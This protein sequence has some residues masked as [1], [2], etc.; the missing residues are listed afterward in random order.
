VDSN[1]KG[2]TEAYRIADDD[3]RG[4]YWGQIWDVRRKEKIEFRRS[5]DLYISPNISLVV[6]CD[7]ERVT[8]MRDA[9]YIQAFG[10]E[11]RQMKRV[12]RPIRSLEDNI[13]MFLADISWEGTHCSNL[14][15]DKDTCRAAV[16]T[17]MN[18][19]VP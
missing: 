15:E 2:R 8:H 4:R 11:M 13:E 6:K 12:G 14:F 5:H 10:G 3:V 16:N 1:F 17:V 19:R 7:A 18:I 9:R